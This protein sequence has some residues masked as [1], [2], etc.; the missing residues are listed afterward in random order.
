MTPYEL[1]KKQEEIAKWIVDHM[2]VS[3]LE[4]IAYE[5]TLEGLEEF[6]EEELKELYPHAFEE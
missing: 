6:T 4:N 3:E 5:Y 2:D 1:I